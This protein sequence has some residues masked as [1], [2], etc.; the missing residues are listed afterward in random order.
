MTQQMHCPLLDAFWQAVLGC[1]QGI[2]HL[3]SQLC[4]CLVVPDAL[5]I[6]QEFDVGSLYAL[7]A[8]ICIKDLA[9]LRGCLHLHAREGTPMRWCV[10]AGYC[11]ICEELLQY[12]SPCAT[13]G[14]RRPP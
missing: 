7:L 2:T 8:R 9:E 11:E 14:H 13:A 12:S 4:W 5:S 6:V 1:K 3:Y 10:T